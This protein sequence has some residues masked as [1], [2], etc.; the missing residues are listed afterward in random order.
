MW[1]IDNMEGLRVAGTVINN[2]RYADD[3]VIIAESKEQLQ[4]LINVIVA[5]CEEKRL[6]LN[7]AISFTM[8]FSKSLT[9][10]TCKTIVN[11]MFCNKYNRSYT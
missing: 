11:G 5:D 2:L 1:N 3:T 10:P 4:G 9:V 8:V 6:M 7:S